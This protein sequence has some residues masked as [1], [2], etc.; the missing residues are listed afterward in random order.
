MLNTST[1]LSFLFVWY[2][3]KFDMGVS[4]GIADLIEPLYFET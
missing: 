3:L 1:L 2:S 4:G